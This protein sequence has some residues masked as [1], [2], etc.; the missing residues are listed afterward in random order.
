M[1]S[2]A[3]VR[4]WTQGRSLDRVFRS[5]AWATV[6]GSRFRPTRACG[7]GP[8][9]DRFHILGARRPTIGLPRPQLSRGG[10]RTAASARRCISRAAR[11][12]RHARRYCFLRP[13]RPLGPER[14]SRLAVGVFAARGIRS[15]RNRRCGDRLHVR[16]AAERAAASATFRSRHSAEVRPR[17]CG[18]QPLLSPRVG[19]RA[20]GG[21]S[22]GSPSRAGLQGERTSLSVGIRARIAGDHRAPPFRSAVLTADARE[23][24][25]IGGEVRRSR[26]REPATYI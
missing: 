13:G 1:R 7:D 26:Q 9:N 22:D 5:P 20:A 19:P 15:R 17:K 23:R 14:S 11:R 8:P 4:A 24:E 18:G 6:R 16:L 2:R 10:W 3:V 25:P 12:R 21:R